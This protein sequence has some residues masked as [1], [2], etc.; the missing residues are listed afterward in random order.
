MPIERSSFKTG[1]SVWTI[2]RCRSITLREPAEIRVC[3][4]HVPLAAVD[5]PGRQ[6]AC[7]LPVS[8]LATIWSLVRLGAAGL[9]V[10]LQLDHLLSLLPQ[11]L[12]RRQVLAAE[13]RV[14]SDEEVVLHRYQEEEEK[15]EK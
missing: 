13:V 1:P 6:L 4:G 11:L 10:R 9:V 3:T 15:R 2:S 7:R 8:I 5:Q 14:E 12:D